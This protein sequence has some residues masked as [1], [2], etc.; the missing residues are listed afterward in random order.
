[1]Q[2]IVQINAAQVW[3]GAS[4]KIPV[5]AGIPDGWISVD[6]LPVLSQGHYA[7]LAG[8][9]RL[10]VVSGTPPTA[11]AI[12]TRLSE[13]IPSLINTATVNCAGYIQSAIDA[14][15]I[16]GTLVFDVPGTVLIDTDY[17]KFVSVQNG[18][19]RAACSILVDRP[20]TIINAARCTLKVK[21]FSS[22]WG[23]MVL[24][25]SV[26]AIIVNSSD[27]L[28]NRIFIDANSDNHYELDGDGFKW[29]ETG[30]TQKR[31][32]NGIV[33]LPKLNDANVKNV[34][35]KN[36]VIDRPLAGIVF[37]GNME[38]E[39][40]SNFLSGARGTGIV[41][42]CIAK[43]NVINRNRGN[44]VQ[45]ASGVYRCT[46]K[47][48][49]INNGMYHAVRFYSAVIDCMSFADKEYVN[50]SSVVASYSADGY[51]RTSK[52]ESTEFKIVRA[53]FCAGGEWN[54]VSG[55]HNIRNCCFI[56]CEG[57]FIPAPVG[58][59]MYYGSGD[60]YMAGVNSVSCPTGFV[61]DG[62]KMRGYLF[63]VGIQSLSSTPVN[64][65]RGPVVKNARIEN[66]KSNGVYLIRA[67]RSVVRDN[68]IIGS[69]VDRTAHVRFDDCPSAAALGN[70][71]ANGEKLGPRVGV[72][73]FGDATNVQI[74]VQHYDEN[75]DATSR[76]VQAAGST[77]PL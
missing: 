49:V 57:V 14:T 47:E 62:A 66:S 24:G 1:M 53:G 40:N 42:S 28:L 36:C 10:A 31:P 68:E 35:I 39:T 6:Q 63:G 25:D 52:A 34:C 22:A 70:S 4:R 74:G 75:I 2:T 12:T 65:W 41:E 56:N 18:S 13:F 3:T 9:G 23:S 44:G 55:V 15:E 76:V 48:N 17:N 37:R 71:F 38:N 32:I 7:A 26:A 64:D 61:I 16:H 51:W 72:Y 59:D 30:P 5:G 77:P 29:W 45:M 19:R 11:R 60:V 58:H 46:S 21:D 27:V 67:P 20:I 43:H 73:V 54:Y 33:V 8:S 69:G 50:C